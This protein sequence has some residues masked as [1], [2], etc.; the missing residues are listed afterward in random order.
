METR[1]IAHEIMLG[2]INTG[3]EGGYDSISCSTAGD[4]PSI[5]V[6]QW[7]GSRADDLLE[8]IPGGD[9]FVDRPFSDIERCGEVEDLR[10]LLD[11]DAGRTAQQNQL[12]DDCMLYVDTLQHVPDLDDSRCIIYAVTYHAYRFMLLLV[13]CYVGHLVLR[14]ALGMELFNFQA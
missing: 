12:E 10:T 2:I 14:Q 9:R 11:S 3:V 5:G 7:E 8:K 13:L 6:S 4:Y 1:E